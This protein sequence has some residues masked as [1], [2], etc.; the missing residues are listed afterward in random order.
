MNHLPPVSLLQMKAIL[1]KIKIKKTEMSQHTSPDP[2]IK[3]GWIYQLCWEKLSPTVASLLAVLSHVMIYVRLCCRGFFCPTLH[4]MIK[5]SLTVVF[6][7]YLLFLL[8]PPTPSFPGF[9]KLAM[10]IVNFPREK[11]NQSMN[12]CNNQ[13][14]VQKYIDRSVYSEQ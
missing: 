13:Y 3:V 11:L 7:F 10:E 2:V 4:S 5:H 6:L 9:S 14:T 1:E 8:Y 12:Q